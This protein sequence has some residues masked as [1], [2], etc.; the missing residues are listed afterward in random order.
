[1]MLATQAIDINTSLNNAVQYISQ[2]FLTSDGTALTTP[3]ITLDGT[4]GNAYFSGNVGIGINP[5]YKL[6]VTR[7]SPSRVGAVIIDD[8][9]ISSDE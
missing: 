1:M 2:I 8:N 3:N 6:D 5:T 4:N 9:T 7:F